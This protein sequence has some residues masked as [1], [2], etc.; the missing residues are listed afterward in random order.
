MRSSVVP[1]LPSL[2]RAQ[3]HARLRSAPA[4][5]CLPAL[6]AQ[7]RSEWEAAI[8]PEG[9]GEFRGVAWLWAEAWRVLPDAALEAESLGAL[10]KLEAEVR[11]DL[12]DEAPDGTSGPGS[13]PP[14]TV[15]WLGWAEGSDARALR[16]RLRRLA[17]P[18]RRQALAVLAQWAVP[19]GPAWPGWRVLAAHHLHDLGLRHRAEDAY[20]AGVG[21]ATPSE[22]AMAQAVARRTALARHV[23]LP[24]GVQ[25]VPGPGP[26]PDGADP[27]DLS[28]ALAGRRLTRAPWL[29]ARAVALARLHD[30]APALPRDLVL[31]SGIE[32]PQPALGWETRAT[33]WMGMVRTALSVSDAELAGVVEDAQRAHARIQAREAARG[34]ALE[35]EE[36]RW[37]PVPRSRPKRSGVRCTTA[38]QAPGRAPP[39]CAPRSAA[40][41]PR[42]WP[43]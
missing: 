43:T 28:L 26:G 15:P 36:V 30:R 25:D 18:A 2:S 16:T 12:D 40:W 8:W 33:H 24:L 22:S 20:W 35:A 21:P 39:C 42:W 19:D 9:P 4:L 7:W 10:L 6:I 17:E 1:T 41:P 5:T 23:L 3:W 27:L 11:P 29:D 34:G 31:E 32:V 37:F 14:A 13:P 38:P